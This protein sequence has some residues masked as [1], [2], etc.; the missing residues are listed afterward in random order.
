MFSTEG[1]LYRTC[2]WIYHFTLLNILFLITCIPIITL[3][4]SLAAAFGVS[5]QWIKK[6]DPPIISTYFKIFRENF[7]QSMIV[8]IFIIIFGLLLYVDF[9]ITTQ[10]HSNLRIAL[11]LFFCIMMVFY[12]AAILHVFPLMVNGYY[13]NKQ[14]LMNAVKFSF[15]KFHITLLNMICIYMIF[16]IAYKFPVIFV[17]FFSSICLFLTY[18][19]INKKFIILEALEKN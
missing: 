16:F 2:V 7:R 1:F 5:R 13:T 6:N 14:L 10:I 11:Y 18:W 19:H 3:F 12:I 17:F 8:G 15:Y 9:Q 4:P